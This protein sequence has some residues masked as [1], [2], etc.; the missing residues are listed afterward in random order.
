ML[1]ELAAVM[2]ALPRRVLAQRPCVDGTD[3]CKAPGAERGCFW[4][5]LVPSPAR[6]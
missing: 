4:F 6:R 2:R 3:R 1:R 5:L